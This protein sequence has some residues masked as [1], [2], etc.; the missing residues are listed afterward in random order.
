[1]QGKQKTGI[2]GLPVEDRVEPEGT[3]E[4]QSIVAHKTANGDS[5]NGCESQSDAEPGRSLLE[6]IMSE[7]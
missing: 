6:A 2:P 4:V 1:M 5:A 7:D 3:S